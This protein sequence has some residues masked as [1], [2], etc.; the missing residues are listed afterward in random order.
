MRHRSSRRDRQYAAIPNKAMRDE[1]LSIEARGLLALL[2]TYSDEWVFR[3][4]HLLDVTGMGTNKFSR[5]MKELVTMGY[6]KLVPIR[7][8]HGQ[9]RG[10]EWIISDEPVTEVTE[11]GVSV[12]ST[13]V[14]ENRSSDNE[15]S[16]QSAPIRKPK[17]EEDQKTKKTKVDLFDEKSDPEQHDPAVILSKVISS[18][19]ADAFVKHRKALKAPLTA[20]AAQI[21]ARQLGGMPEAEDVVAQSIMQGWKGVFPV[22]K[23]QAPTSQPTDAERQRAAI[24]ARMAQRATGSV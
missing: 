21:M 23:Q 20:N 7:N 15:M 17:G 13:E 9:V 11:N 22:K 10:R 8:E 16:G 14:T 19:M 12:G 1:R 5:V 3:K 6:V 18:E 4:D 2:M 24:Q